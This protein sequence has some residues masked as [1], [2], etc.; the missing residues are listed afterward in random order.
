LAQKLQ[1]LEPVQREMDEAK[2]SVQRAEQRMMLLVKARDVLN[3]KIQLNG[4]YNESE[5]T[6]DDLY[7][8]ENRADLEATR[9]AIKED[10]PLAKLQFSMAILDLLD[11]IE[12]HLSEGPQLIH[13]A[14][15]GDVAVAEASKGNHGD[16]S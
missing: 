3:G 9:D 10:L 1:E 4:S 11:V 13:P 5:I 15:L 16:G 12:K 14:G 6:A 7:S 8:E 2:A